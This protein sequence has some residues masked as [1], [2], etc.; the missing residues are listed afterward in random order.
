MR[1]KTTN[2]YTQENKRRNRNKNGDLSDSVYDY[3]DNNSF[4]LF[5]SPSFLQPSVSHIF[6]SPSLSFN[7]IIIINKKDGGLFV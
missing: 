4:F 3:Y 5:V 1:E 7:I 6:Q 2:T